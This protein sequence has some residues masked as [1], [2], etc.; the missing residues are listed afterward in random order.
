MIPIERLD[1]AA[2]HLVVVEPIPRRA[3]R[4]MA[5]SAI[6]QALPAVRAGDVHRL[7]TIWSFG[8]VPSAIHFADRLGTAI[9]GD[10]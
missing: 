3:E 5:D 1:Q 9:D 10:G 6:W 8:G 4:M 2:D 7:E